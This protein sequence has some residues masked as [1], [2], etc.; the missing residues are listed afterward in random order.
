MGLQVWLPLQGNLENKG[1]GEINNIQGTPSYR[2]NGKIGSALELNTK[3]TIS[4]SQLANLST[5]TLCFWVNVNSST[6][7]T[8]N[9]TDIIGFNDISSTGTQGVFRCEQFQ[10]HPPV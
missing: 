8:T 4:S 5:F 6:S 3:I 10:A 2:A 1:L 9:W 7:L